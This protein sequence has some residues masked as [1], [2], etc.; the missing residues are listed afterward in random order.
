MSDQIGR[1]D[2]C[3]CGSGKKYKKCCYQSGGSSSKSF[4]KRKFKV[5]G[6]EEPVANEAVEE[7]AAASP[8]DAE[9]LERATERE[10]AD[11]LTLFSRVDYR[12][13]PSIPPVKRAH[14]EEK[15]NPYSGE[16]HD[17]E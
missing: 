7:N 15:E 5:I 4:T 8:E 12:Q 6:K 13:V 10:S 3:P 2:P 16:R 9:A 17:T 14:D 11:L 1:N